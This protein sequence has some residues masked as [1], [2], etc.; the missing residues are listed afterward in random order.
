[1]KLI[2]IF[3]LKVVLTKLQQE[4]EYNFLKTKNF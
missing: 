3:D 1:M 2:I 4:E